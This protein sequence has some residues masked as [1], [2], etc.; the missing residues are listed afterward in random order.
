MFLILDNEAENA[1]IV[2]IEEQSGVLPY[3]TQPLPHARLVSPGER[4]PV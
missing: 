3:A 2:Q 4:T 1:E